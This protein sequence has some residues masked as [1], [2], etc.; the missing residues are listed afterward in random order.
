MRV[1][2]IVGLLGLSVG[3]AAA[4]AH[5]GAI[6]NLLHGIYPPESALRRALDQCGLRDPSFNRLDVKAREA[7]YNSLLPTIEPEAAGAHLPMPPAHFV[8][9]WRAAGYGH[10]SPNDV[11]SEQQTD[12]Y[13]HPPVPAAP[14]AR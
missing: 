7:C 5:P 6:R 8:D 9:L 10:M 4:A 2:W 11:R 12:R 3:V 13:N 1:A 14:V